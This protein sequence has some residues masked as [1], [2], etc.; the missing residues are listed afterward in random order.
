MSDVLR[1]YTFLPWLR[2][3]IGGRIDTVDPLG[4]NPGAPQE[5][6]TVDIHFDVNTAEVSNSVS[7]VGPGDVIGINERA[8]VK[9]EPRDWITN[10]EPNYLPYI[11]FYDEEFPWRYT[12]AKA[13]ATHRL[14]PWLILVAMSD[15]EFEDAGVVPPPENKGG[16]P[17]SLVR[18]TG[19]PNQIF[20]PPAQTWAW[21]HVQTAEDISENGSLG[22]QATVD[23]L[24]RL[25][26]ANPDQASSR[27]LCPRKL[28]PNTAYHAMLLPAFEIGRLAG[29]SQDTA[30]TDGLA[31]SW[32]AGQVDYPV[33]YRWY[34]RTSER[35]DFEYLVEL[36]EP[37]PVAD[38][39]GIRDMDMQTPG[40][41]L[42]GL[43]D[44]PVMGLEGALRKPGAVARPSA[45]PPA[46]PSPQ[47]LDDLTQKVN[48]GANSL[49]APADGVPHP[50]PV[51]TMPLYGRWH[52]S[53][54][55]LDPAQAGWVHELNADPRLRTASGFG[56]R[57]IQSRQED[58]MKRAWQQVGPVIKA[59]SK[60]R[61]TQLSIPASH[62]ILQKNLKSLPSDQLLALTAPVH[63]RILGS[64][65]TIR[66]QI[67]ESRLPQ[68]A[69]SPTFRAL[70]R[71]RGRLMR[72]AFPEAGRKSADLI[73]RLNDGLVTAAPPKQAPEGQIDI[74]KISSGLIPSWLP[75][76]LKYLL[77]RPPVWWLLFLLLL[78]ILY[79]AAGLGLIFGV[80]LAALAVLAGGLARLSRQ[81]RIADAISENG[82]TPETAAAVPPRPGFII[83]EPGATHAASGAA[84]GGDSLEARNFRA[85]TIALAERL[86]L[87]PPPEAPKAPLD[88]NLLAGKLTAALDPKRAVLKRLAS[89]INIGQVLA[90]LQPF[91][92]I[93][94]AMAHPSFPDAMYKPLCDISTELL[95][96]NLN[97]IPN[98]TISLMEN[99]RRFIE[100]YLV[101]LN[102]EFGRELLWREYLTDQRGSYFRQFW[103]IGDTLPSDTSADPAAVEESLR[104]ITPLHTWRK[105]TRLGVHQ[106]RDIPTGAEP[107]ETRLVMVLRGELLKKYP[108]TVVF[109]Q[110]A[111]WGPDPDP[112]PHLA[113]GR[114]VRLLD[115][116]GA[117]GTVL[118][119]IFKAEIE[120][121]IHF[122]GFNLTASVAKGSKLREDDDPGWFF[123]L[124]ERP[125]EPRFGLD[126]VTDGAPPS[127]TDWNKLAWDHL[128]D[129]D[130]INM[131]DLNTVPTTNIPASNPDRAV[132][133]GANAADMAY[134]LYQDPVMVAFHAG[135]MLE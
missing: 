36:I 75:N 39:V 11:E 66:Q 99:N 88:L 97:R 22:V 100:A 90:Q 52:G 106:N 110:R 50:D 79:L 65:T 101:G 71:P 72:K 68:A 4:A 5:R 119:P 43:S 54:D 73:P 98:N 64:A 24:E 131:I 46:G 121:D 49:Q 112:P 96:P 82:I 135:D 124:Q 89:I 13:T 41:G 27:L 12:Q 80:V 129:I 91:E 40:F 25:V 15:T 23:E 63:P 29:L 26:A 111:K 7:L 14:R 123:V 51:V 20:P 76:W 92:T 19:D 53:V 133:W 31:P 44:P 102:H 17:L 70:T 115:D 30:G 60:I 1:T 126:V 130:A 109:A 84:G 114:E 104:D 10:F 105:A 32:G 8:I 83:T 18:I 2:Q 34:F 87:Q 108:T 127:I 42:T 103:D 116:S 86:A 57:V 120:P 48:L 35:G 117:D 78:P 128:G 122:F 107:G 45:W 59:N 62:Q 58:Y 95:V 47:F 132:N 6:A 113:A 77:R 55:R 69:V 37:R 38:E 118:T 56:T 134:I 94:E 93:V 125:G 16:A 61:Q 21:A 28:R 33:Y 3:G 85:A 74:K 9:T 81:L 67:A